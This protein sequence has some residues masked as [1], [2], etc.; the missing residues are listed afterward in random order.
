MQFSAMTAQVMPL[1]AR[2]RANIWS[3]NRSMCCT[4]Q[5]VNTCALGKHMIIDSLVVSNS[6]LDAEGKS[7]VTGTMCLGIAQVC[8]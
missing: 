6:I 4:E 8:L 2:K 7:H 1:I 3:T 5:Q